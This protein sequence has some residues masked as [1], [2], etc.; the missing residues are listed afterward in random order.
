[1]N[2]SSS[3]ARRAR[4]ETAEAV[5]LGY[6]EA[7]L[8][9]YKRSTFNAVPGVTLTTHELAA[10]EAA[11]KEAGRREREAEL[12]ADFEAAVATVRTQVTAALKDFAGERTAYYQQIEG[13]VVQLALSIARKILQRESTI[14]P[15]LLAGIVHVALRDIESNTEVL[16]RV[17]SAQAPA[18]RTFFAE[19]MDARD[20]PQVVD[21]P[22]LEEGHCVLQ[23]LLGKT[24]LGPEVQLK[25]IAQGLGDLLAKRPGTPR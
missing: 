20:L 15:L 24:E 17:N 1:M 13:E 22:S 25:E 8:D 10:R 16:V 19:H 7:E 12:R 3:G 18:W 9:V 14:D 11:A 4:A 21:D 2:S 6:A 5:P 23:T